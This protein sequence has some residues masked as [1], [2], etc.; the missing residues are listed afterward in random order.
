MLK[1]VLSLKE[2]IENFEWSLSL[3]SNAFQRMGAANEKAL[4][5]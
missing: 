4:R 5:S 1:C 2:D 3:S